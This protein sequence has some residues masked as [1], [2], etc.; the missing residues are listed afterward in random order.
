MAGVFSAHA[1]TGKSKCLARQ[2]KARRHASSLSERR[3]DGFGHTN[4]WPCIRLSSPCD[5][6][7]RGGGKGIRW[8]GSLR[9]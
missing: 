3:K 2:G 9:V 4:S 6:S 8:W 5:G 1:Q 7:W